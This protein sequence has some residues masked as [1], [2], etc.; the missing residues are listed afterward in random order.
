[1][2]KQPER[3]ERTKQKLKASFWELYSHKPIEKISVKEI[4]EAA[5][6]YRST[7]YTYYSDMYA[8]LEEI[9]AE[10]METYKSFISRVYEV[11]SFSDTMQLLLELYTHNA[12]QLAILLGPYGDPSFLKELKACI[13]TVIHEKLNVPEDDTD[14]EIL[15]EMGSA[16]V[17]SMLT[18]WY[19]HRDTISIEE[20]VNVSSRFMQNGLMPYMQKWLLI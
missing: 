4:T 18:Y 14:T 16:A 3:T 12:E 2:K 13:K 7:F 17:I 19:E 5:G 15:I 11:H 9:E 1:M 6:L 20:T 8:I 10:L